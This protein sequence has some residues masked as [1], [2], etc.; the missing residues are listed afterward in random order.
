MALALVVQP[1]AAA[2]AQSAAGE[3]AELRQSIDAMKADY[4]SRLASLEERLARAERLASGAERDA[5]EAIELAEQTA[6]DQSQGSSSPNTFNPAIGVILAGGYADI[7]AGWEEI[8]GFA[9]AGEIGTGDSGFF[10][11][12]AELNLQANIDSRYYGSLTLGLHEEDGAAE[13]GIEEAWLQT[14]T[15]PAGLSAHAGRF[16]SSAGYLNQFHFHSDDFVDRPLPYQAFYGG[17]YTVDGIRAR[18]LAPTGLLFELGGE[19]N[20]GGSFPATANGETSPGAYTLFANLGGDVGASHSYLFGLSYTSADAVDRSGGHDVLEE[21]ESF[22]GDSDLTVFDFVWKWAPGGNNAIRNFK[23]QGEYF[24]RKEEGLYADID[25]DGEQT[26]WYAQGVWQFVPM[27]R[28][29]LR[30]DRLDADNG[31]LLAGTALE[32]PGRSAWRN[33]LMLDWSPSEYSRLRLQYTEDKVLS[34]T[35][36]QWYLQYIMSIGAHGAH[37][38]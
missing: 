13:V 4:E 10:V 35:D 23:I 27:F 34:E 22:S 12:E 15:L 18:W 20:W 8:P 28:V 36:D 14:T 16:F 3:I 17:R 5:E 7:G 26:G 33:S 9:P 6:I 37:Q 29:G 1:V 31:P 24:S 19:A 38:F 21:P 2:N 25:Y 32:D 11:G 30:H